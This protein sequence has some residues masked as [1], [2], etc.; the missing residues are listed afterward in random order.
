M[1]AAVASA[2]NHVLRRWLGGSL[3]KGKLPCDGVQPESQVEKLQRWIDVGMPGR[4]ITRI[5][6]WPL[7]CL[8]ASLKW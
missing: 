3:G 2:H 4:R 6:R 8:A 1:A 5:R 7:T